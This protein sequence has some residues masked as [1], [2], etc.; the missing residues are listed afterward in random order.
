MSRPFRAA[1]RAAALRAAALRAAVA[2]KFTRA[3][4]HG[5]ERAAL[6]RQDELNDRAAQGMLTKSQTYA[7]YGW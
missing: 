2:P 5:R 6:R 7:K 1:A 4:T 3:Y